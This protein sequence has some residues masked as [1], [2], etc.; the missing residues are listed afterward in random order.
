VRSVAAAVIGT[1]RALA[2]VSAVTSTTVTDG[3]FSSSPKSIASGL[4]Q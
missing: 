2:V 3:T 4:P 1:S